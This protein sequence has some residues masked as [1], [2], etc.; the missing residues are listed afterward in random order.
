MGLSGPNK[1]ASYSNSKDKCETETVRVAFVKN[2][3]E[4]LWE[5]EESIGEKKVIPAFSLKKVIDDNRYEVG[6]LWKSESRPQDNK[7]Q[8]VFQA[9]A[10]RKRLVKENTL[11]AC[12]KVL[13][14]EYSELGAIER[15][16]SPE[17]G[18]YMPHHAVVRSSAS[19][20]NM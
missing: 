12:E 7:Q 20:T 18:Y 6:L 8:A 3:I 10:L 9:I 2:C 4:S 1:I 16:S 11:D 17:E 19:T 14:E 13:L 5:M 15:D